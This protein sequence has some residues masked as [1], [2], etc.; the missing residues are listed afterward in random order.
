MIKYRIELTLELSHFDVIVPF[1]SSYC[2]KLSLITL[3]ELENNAIIN[4]LFHFLLKKI[5][6]QFGTL[7]RFSF[8]IP[9][10]PFAL[11]LV[12]SS[13]EIS[14]NLLFVEVH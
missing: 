10:D 12:V 14:K 13:F 8:L 4:G 5:L 7:S 1:N 3:R 11:N 9:T 2:F 6:R